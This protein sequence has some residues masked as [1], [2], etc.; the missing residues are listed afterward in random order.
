MTVDTYNDDV[1][2][3]LCWSLVFLRLKGTTNDLFEQ[4][5]NAVFAIL[6]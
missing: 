1:T 3:T 2:W 6:I 4:V 5:R